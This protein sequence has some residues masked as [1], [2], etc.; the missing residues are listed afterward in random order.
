M[1]GGCT[2][3]SLDAQP[4]IAARSAAMRGSTLETASLFEPFSAAGFR[5]RNRVVM[6]PM[7][8]WRSPGGVPGD[9][10]AAY[11]ARRARGG[12]GLII[13]EGVN[14]DH[15]GASGY[16]DVPAMFGDQALRGWRAVVDAV[17]AAKSAIIPQ[18]WHVGA[19]RRAGVGPDPRVPGFGPARVAQDGE[20]VVRRL[21]D[22]GIED[23]I[24]SYGRGAR[25]AAD[26]GFDGVEIH[27]A[28][29]YLLDQFFW[30]RTNRRRDR[31]G[32]PIE[33]RAR[34]AAEVVRE[35]RNQIPRG[36]PIIFRFSQ[37][38]M[39]DYEARLVAD[40]ADLTRL[41]AP[42]CDAGVDIFH[43]STRRFWS[44]AFAGSPQS[45]ARWTRDLTGRPVIA[46]GSVGLDKAH[47]SR[48]LG[49][50]EAAMAEVADL[51]RVVDGLAHCDFDLIAVGRGMLAD[52]EWSNKVRLG[53]FADI[54]PLRPHHLKT[55]T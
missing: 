19:F 7:T 36:M 2:R 55:L 22:R 10:V 40:P 9:N 18:L 11:Y 28:H 35:V 42:L 49:G 52:A 24:H 44:P 43:A 38:K 39:D 41:L 30:A 33:N 34:F 48:A 37:W 16:D 3:M 54:N 6:A 4:G 27:G 29:G 51:D 20:T 25:A 45:L 17:H 26:A 46:V 1:Q 47:Q 8:R 14:I 31:F 5:L 21:D 15:G 23:I 53:Q 12:A 50:H 13:T 32:G